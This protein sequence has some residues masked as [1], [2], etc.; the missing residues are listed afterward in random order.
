M[1]AIFVFRNT[2]PHKPLFPVLPHTGGIT[3]FFKMITAI[4][5]PILVYPDQPPLRIER[6]FTVQISFFLTC[7]V[8]NIVGKP[9]LI[10][11]ISIC[12]FADFAPSRPLRET[13]RTCGTPEKFTPAWHTTQIRLHL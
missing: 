10:I 8:N 2:G 9:S 1:V 3:L 12:S 13:I 11:I 5:K 6:V 4:V 7:I